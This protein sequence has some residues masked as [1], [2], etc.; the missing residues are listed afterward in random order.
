MNDPVAEIERARHAELVGKNGKPVALELEPGLAPSEIESIEQ[1]LGVAVP[2]EVR[3]VLEHTAA[4][5][6]PWHDLD[7]S[8]RTLSFEAEDMFP[9]GLPIAPDGFGNHWV[10]DLTPAERETASVFFVCHDPP[11]VLFQ[12]SSLAAFLREWFRRLS[13]PH[14]SLVVDV[15]EDRP[16]NVWGTNLGE[17]DHD[18]ALAADADL[19][20]FATEL[21]DQ[22]VFVDLRKSEIGMGFSWGRFGPRTHVVRHGYE[23]LFAYRRPDERPGLFRR[24]FG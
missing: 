15:Q 2:R 23:R 14:A 12:S 19:R 22:F 5:S 8:G 3:D 10:L 7:F 17:I 4:I 6:V 16:F 11:V 9:S 21:G 20:A 18:A 1:E 24:L 13:P